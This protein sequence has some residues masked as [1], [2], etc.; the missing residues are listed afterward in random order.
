MNREKIFVGLSGG[1]DS[2]VA[3]A[4]LKEQ[5]FDVQ[6]VFIRIALPGYP[7]SAGEDKVWAMRA[8]A[9]LR[10]PF[11]EIDLSEEY[12]KRVFELS[13]EEFARG[14]TPNPDALCNREIKF[15]IF[16]EWCMKQGA[17]F[18]ATGHYAQVKD[19]LLYMGKDTQKD[20]SYFLWAVP[21]QTL[22]RV[23]FPVGAFEK[24]DVRE[25]ARSRGLPHADKKDSQ[26]LCFLGDVSVEDM[27]RR[28]VTLS[29]GEVLDEKGEVV[30][31]HDGAQ[32]YTLG[33]RHGFTLSE[34]GT[35][36]PAHYVIGKDAAANTVT[37]SPERIPANKK[38]TEISLEDPNWIGDVPDGPCVAR[39]R[40]RGVLIPAELKDGSVILKEA[41]YVP[42]G[43]SLV[44]YRGERCLGGATIVGA[45]LR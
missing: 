38:S 6:G 42:E 4:L 41:H 24:S 23:L 26:G 28:E 21:H 5:G 32:A 13:M 35:S 8:A 31:R 14:R 25:M 27:L 29:P 30:G 17:H 1:V 20:Q 15:G 3:A 7:C 16:F 33:Q 11:E 19:G 36:V 22:K 10:I 2:S 40:Y 37:V 39:F 18:V 9:H 44:L 12:K 43:Q 34:H 45:I